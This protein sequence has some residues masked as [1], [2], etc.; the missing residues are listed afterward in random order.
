MRWLALALLALAL[1]GCESS[2]EK[3]AQ[4]EREAQ[5]NGSAHGSTQQGL[6]ITHPS[7]KVKVLATGV[8]R[9]SETDAVVVVLHNTSASTLRD[10]PVAITVRDSRGATVYSNDVPGLASTLVEVQLLAPH[11]TLSW[12]D[13]QV[14]ASGGVPSS[15]AARIGEA[16][17]G[18]GTPPPVSVSGTHVVEEAGSAAALEGNVV[19]SSQVPQ[20]E[21][22]VYA[23]AR[24]GGR[25]VAAGRAV[26]PQ[27]PAAR[28]THFQLFFV[29]SPKGAKLEVSAPATTLG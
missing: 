2:Q 6:K 3:S 11:A 27:L 24:Q 20:Q 18:T 26:L 25:V 22:V 10:V 9:G 1:S 28:P 16:P 29:G 13:D 23:V 15:V 21:L 8:V 7:T 19:N 17:T 5:K 4:L 12:I 14:Q